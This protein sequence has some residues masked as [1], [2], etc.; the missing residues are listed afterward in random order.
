MKAAVFHAL[1]T[2]LAIEEIPEPT[3]AADELVIRVGRCGICG[4]D[5]HMTEEPAFGVQPGA[6]LGHE[7][8]GEIVARGPEAH[9]FA[10]G[11]CVAV[12]PLRGCGKCESCLK[13]E[14]AWCAKMMLQGGGYAEFTT[15]TA[16]QCLKLPRTT[17]VEDGALVEP[18]AV[19]L[20]GVMLSGLT[21]GARV[22][23][24]GAGPI[25]LGA[26]FWAKRR[27]AAKVAVADVATLQEDLAYRV[28]ATDF[29]DVKEDAIARVNAALG[30][31]P[32]IVF[33]CV[34]KPGILAQ[35]LEYVR[36]R[37]TIV[38][39]GLCTAPD[40]FVPFR[41]VSKEVRFVTSAFFNSREYQAALDALDGGH[42]PP[43]AMITD[44]V[45]LSAM[46][47]AFEALRRRTIQ[48]KVMVKPH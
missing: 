15:A 42:A 4:S 10:I 23:V 26:A 18:L 48:C 17:S 38:M 6:V 27:G 2:P 3:P 13:G 41:A 28:G 33:E 39:L 20:H 11:D 30:G 1:K 44:T 47:A 16:R 40:S 43:K 22:L 32:D 24:L 45:A 8:A 21:P 31:P 35:A 37:G 7:F 29:I 9:G 34:G 5:L 36:S 46:P 19:A 14:P 12:S 25:G